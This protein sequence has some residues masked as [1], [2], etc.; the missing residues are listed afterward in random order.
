MHTDSFIL[1]KDAFLEYSIGRMQEK[2]KAIS[3]RV[4]EH[5]WLNPVDGIWSMHLDDGDCP[6]IDTNGKGTSKLAAPASALGEFFERLS[7]NDFWSH[8]Y[9]GQTY[10]QH[11]FVHYPQERWFQPGENGEWPAELLTPEL[12]GFYNP[13]GSIDAETLVEYNSGNVERGICALPYVRQRDGAD[14]WFPVNIIGN[15]YVSNGM[16]A[17]NIPPEA[18]AGTVGTFRAPRQVPHH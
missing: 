10:A 14:V 3:F 6:L 18:R 13:E 7:C 5:S 2:L 8:Y 9:L 12:Q 4:E 17:G 16:S 11:R 15:L 1:G